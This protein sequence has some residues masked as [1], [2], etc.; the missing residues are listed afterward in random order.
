MVTFHS[1]VSL[2]EGNFSKQIQEMTLNPI[3]QFTS[4]HGRFPHF[5]SA[6]WNGPHPRAAGQSATILGHH[7]KAQKR[8][9]LLQTDWATQPEVPFWV[10]QP[11]IFRVRTGPSIY[12][13]YSASTSS[14]DKHIQNSKCKIYQHQHYWGFF[15]GR[16]TSYI[17]IYIYLYLDSPSTHNHR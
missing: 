14:K 13:S 8:P 9:L 3:V 10:D 16:W 12:Y 17:Y 1:Y 4:T 5:Q 7:S 6:T 11:K 15:W 2:P